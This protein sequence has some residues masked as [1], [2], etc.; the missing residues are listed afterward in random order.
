MYKKLKRFI[1][2]LLTFALVISL[3]GLT[4]LAHA[5]GDTITPFGNWNT[6][7][8]SD[9]NLIT[10]VSNSQNA[11]IKFTLSV[12]AGC[13]ANYSVELVPNER[14]GSLD[15]ISG[16]YTN[17]SSV[18]AS[19]VISVRVKY[20]SDQYSVSA[21]YQ[22]G[23]QHD[24]H[25]HEDKESITSKLV[26]P[27]TTNRFIWDDAAISKWQ[28][29]RAIEFVLTFASGFVISI[30]C[31]MAP[32]YALLITAGYSTISFAGGLYSSTKVSDSIS[33]MYTPQKNWSFEIK[34]VVTNN[35]YNRTLV[36]Y[37]QNGNL[38]G[39]YALSSAQTYT[40]SY[41]VY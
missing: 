9:P 6:T 3:P 5:V 26:T 35:G 37:D 2:Q 7:Y 11:I 18:R 4:T 15:T 10:N 20:F 33:I 23:T 25:I 39:T 17:T 41:A 1:A 40:I 38:N 29:E 21:S 36:V 22:T 30:A 16:T 14:T 32:Q 12:P 28:T 13:T 19:K 34:Y 27:V 8:E 24:K 31:G